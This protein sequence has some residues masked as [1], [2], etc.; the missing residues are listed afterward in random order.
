MANKI[1]LWCEPA[2]Q[3]EFLG[4]AMAETGKA[5]ASHLSSSVYWSKHDMGLTSNRK[6]E[7]YDKYYPDGYELVWLD[8]PETDEGWNIAFE[9]NQATA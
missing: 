7:F 3:G 8:N 9:R 4:F 1:Y 6:H 2:G 5:F